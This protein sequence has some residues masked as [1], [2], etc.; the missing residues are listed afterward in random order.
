MSAGCICLQLGISCER[1]YFDLRE[2]PSYDASGVTDEAATTP[3]DDGV[4]RVPWTGNS[5]GARGLSFIT[6][7]GA[8]H[9]LGVVGLSDAGKSTFL[10][11]LYLLQS[12]G[13]SLVTGSFAGSATLGGWDLLARGMRLTSPDR[14]RFPPHTPISAG[15]YPGMLHLALRA[16]EGQL[17]DLVLTDASGEWFREWSLDPQSPAAE[18]A[19]WIVAEA[20]A[21][22]LF[23]DCERLSGTPQSAAGPFRETLRLAER[24]RD[25]ANGRRVG[26]VWA[27]ADQQPIPQF[28]TRLEEQFG[29]FFPG[30]TS[31][32]V[33]IKAV[34]D[35][36]RERL[37]RYLEAVDWA[38][39]PRTRGLRLVDVAPEAPDLFFR[40]GAR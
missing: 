26:I 23:V 38:A 30:H 13:H 29:R 27:K 9:L 3:H 36:N 25:H 7:R 10:L 5:L 11:M 40:I 19:R 28:R 4:H 32:D 12:R 33:T 16:A 14:P 35:G 37:G 22:L 6:A 2:C 31:F 39:Q 21:F 18:G 34:H 15:R 20:D 24:L 1:G 8:T 17:R